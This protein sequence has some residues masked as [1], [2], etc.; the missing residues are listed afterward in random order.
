MLERAVNQRQHETRLGLGEGCSI[1]VSSGRRLVTMRPLLLVDVDGV[2]SPYAAESCPRGYVEHHLFPGEVPV[3]LCNDHGRLLRELAKTY[4]LVWATGWGDEA[5]RLISPLLGLPEFPVISF[6]PVPFD[7]REKLS[8]VRSFVGERPKAWIDD[9]ISS[10][11]E[12]WARERAEPTLLIRVDPSVG[13][14][15]QTVETLKLWAAQLQEDV[16]EGKSPGSAL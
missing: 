4:D 15:E 1:P 2:L 10:E 14:T 3:R 7:F 5:P 12:L 16:R 11:A 9:M 13:F 8:A 6:P